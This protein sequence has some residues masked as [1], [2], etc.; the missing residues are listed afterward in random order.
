MARSALRRGCCAQHLMV[1]PRLRNCWPA[2]D[3]QSLICCGAEAYFRGERLA[4]LPP[5][6]ASSCTT[7]ARAAKAALSRLPGLVVGP[8]GRAVVRGSAASWLF[9]P[10]RQALTLL[11][12]H[13]PCLRCLTFE[14][15]G[16][17]RQDA[18]PGPVKMYRVPPARAWWLAVGAPLE[19]GVRPQFSTAHGAAFGMSAG[20]IPLRVPLRVLSCALAAALATAW[21]DA[22]HTW[23]G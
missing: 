9:S 13:W 14:L 3:D 16:R 8:G 1:R 19:R 22:D 6:A 12:C 2:Q 4:P 17:R 11:A 21:G 20:S 5:L 23:S 18:R 7:G 10:R 15:S